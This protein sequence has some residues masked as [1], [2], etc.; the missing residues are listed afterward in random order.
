MS[1]P[2]RASALC[3]F[4]IEDFRTKIVLILLFLF[5]VFFIFLGNL[6]TKTFNILDSC[7]HDMN[8]K[9]LWARPYIIYPPPK[10]MERIKI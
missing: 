6:T 10:W 7:E 3:T 1:L 2:W 5:N 8:V 4:I 9:R